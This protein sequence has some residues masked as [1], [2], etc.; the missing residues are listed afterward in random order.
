MTF[1][2]R[3]CFH[4]LA[5]LCG[6]RSIGYWEIFLL[7]LCGVERVGREVFHMCREGCF[8]LSSP[9]LLPRPYDLS[10][11]W[12]YWPLTCLVTLSLLF[13]KGDVTDCLPNRQG[14][15][16]VLQTIKSKGSEVP[17]THH[18]YKEHLFISETLNSGFVHISV[19]ISI[20]KHFIRHHII[21]SQHLW[22]SNFRNFCFMQLYFGVE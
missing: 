4:F 14:S 19:Q 8:C 9:P 15:C 11:L 12:A 3:N 5:V 10:Y 1:C 18:N 22:Y 16:D 20:Q 7:L 21:F 2:E 13:H 17:L 6:Q